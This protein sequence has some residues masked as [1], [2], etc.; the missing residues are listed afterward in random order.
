[1]TRKEAAKIIGKPAG[2]RTLVS[3]NG[4]NGDIIKAVLAMDTQA[5]KEVAPLAGRFTGA[6]DWHTAFNIWAWMQENIAYSAD[7][8]YSQEIQSPKALLQSGVGDCKSFSVMARALLN[9]HGIT[10]TGYRFTGYLGQKYPSHVYNYFGEHTLDAT[11]TGF[12][13]EPEY[14]FKKDF[15]MQTI[16][17]YTISGI[18]EAAPG[19]G[20][21]RRPAVPLAD[22][23]L[24]AKRRIN[25]PA[26]QFP[27]MTLDQMLAKIESARPFVEHYSNPKHWAY[28]Q[29]NPRIMTEY[30][31]SSNFLARAQ[32]YLTDFY[33]DPEKIKLLIVGYNNRLWAENQAGFVVYPPNS[34][35]PE[36][37]AYF[38]EW[39]K[40][41]RYLGF[42]DAGL[43]DLL[44]VMAAEKTDLVKIGFGQQAIGFV[45]TLVLIITA[46]TGL[47]SSIS[48]LK[49]KAEDQ[50]QQ[51]KDQLKAEGIDVDQLR[52]DANRLYNDGKNLWNQGAG[53]SGGGTPGT[54]GGVP[55]QNPPAPT[56]PGATMFA[57]A[58]PL[59]IGVAALAAFSL[60]KR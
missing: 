49:T 1:M 19:T 18:G 30:V 21:S 10:G 54:G 55:G 41:M 47:I 59:L 58:S 45:E 46:L 51:F 44:V 52:N 48:S 35:I 31:V 32:V 27:G 36:T 38:D 28:L 20:T 33:N 16:N 26:A 57:G 15:P 5:C 2:R 12:D 3:E 42:S 13:M 34:K 8:A 23:Y 53:T 9:C 11:I 29:G 40:N 17:V 6:T 56:T 14:K 22:L 43:F 7:P 39:A 4:T 60:F 24:E 50:Y 25:N 37:I